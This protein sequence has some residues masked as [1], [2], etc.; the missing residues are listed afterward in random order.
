MRKPVERVQ[1][2]CLT[3]TRSVAHSRGSPG[4]AKMPVAVAVAVA[5]AVEGGIAAAAAA[6]VGVA[7]PLAV[8]RVGAELVVESVTPAAVERVEAEPVVEAVN[9][10]VDGAIQLAVEPIES[11]WPL[12][13]L[14]AAKD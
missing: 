5:A 4:V 14:V 10:V 6:A 3:Q 1:M 12:V 13:E 8:E 7:I 2:D 11:V 9:P